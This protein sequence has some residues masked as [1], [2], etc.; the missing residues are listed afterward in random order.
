MPQPISRRRYVTIAY[1]AE[2]LG[3]TDRTIRHMIHDGRLTDYRSGTR[4][5]R[6]D[7]DEIDTAMEPF[8]GKVHA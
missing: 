6:V 2:Y 3:V 1:A 7:L 8:G 5:V 4:A